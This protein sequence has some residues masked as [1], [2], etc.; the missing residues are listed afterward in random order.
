MIKPSVNAGI[1]EYEILRDTAGY[2]SRETL[3]K[4]LYRKYG[5]EA[6]VYDIYEDLQGI[7]RSVNT[8]LEEDRFREF[9]EIAG[10]MPGRWKD[11]RVSTGRDKWWKFSVES[12]DPKASWL[13]DLALLKVYVSV[14]EPSRVMEVFCRTVR[15]LLEQSDNRFHAKVSRIK[16]KDSMCFWVSR[17]SCFLLQKF[18]E[19]NHHVIADAL[20]FIAYRGKLGIS[21]ELATFDSHNSIQ[22]LLI[23]R[24]FRTVKNKDEV[25]LGDMYSLMMQAW[26]GNLPDKHPLAEAFRYER[27]QT[28]LLLLDTMDIITGKTDFTDEHFLLQENGCL[29]HALGIA[30]SWEMAEKEYQI[31]LQMQSRI[32]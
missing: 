32:I 18:F 31:E 30:S 6:S 7:D 8:G 2:L 29:W 26:N 13:R 22:A 12:A 10:S 27:A 4:D 21:R 15:L 19:D 16:R 5:S 25:D 20:P 14:D 24:Y 28:I 17:Y 9:K 11:C 3:L 23:S 1:K